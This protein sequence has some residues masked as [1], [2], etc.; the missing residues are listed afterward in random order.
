MKLS[1]SHDSN[2]TSPQ[3]RESLQ[4]AL[5]EKEVWNIH[6]HEEPH[7]EFF[8]RCWKPQFVKTLY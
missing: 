4:E 3:D 7:A 1:Q 2:K 8:G 6:L 5:G